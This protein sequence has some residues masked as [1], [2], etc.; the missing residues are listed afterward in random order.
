MTT[1]PDLHELANMPG[2]GK[3]QAIL[4][5]AGFIGEDPTA[6]RWNVHVIAL[7][8]ISVDVVVRADSEKEAQNIVERRLRDDAFWWKVDFDEG[9]IFDAETNGVSRV[10]EDEE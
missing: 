8:G 4:M 7:R 3:A 10:M 2:A 1:L 9:D 6:P 5:D